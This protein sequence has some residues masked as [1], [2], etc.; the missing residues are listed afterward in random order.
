GTP[1]LFRTRRRGDKTGIMIQVRLDLP[2]WIISQL[3]GQSSVEEGTTLA[4]FL[5][6]MAVA[7]PG[8]RESVFNPD[9]GSI[10]EQISVALNN[11]VLTFREISEKRLSAG[12]NITLL[13]IYTGG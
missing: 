4:E 11:R 9:A 3:E 1:K 10:T 5:T 7:Y 6:K 13:P 2:P 12:D 8:F